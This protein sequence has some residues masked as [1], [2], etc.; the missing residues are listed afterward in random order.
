MMVKVS[1]Y[2]YSRIIRSLLHLL[3]H[4]RPNI[5]CAVGRLNRYTHN[6]NVSIG[7]L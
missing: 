6:P 5:I 2:I 3:N 7:V 4:T 1:H